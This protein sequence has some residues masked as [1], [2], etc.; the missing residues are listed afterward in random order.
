MSDEASS[1]PDRDNPF[2]TYGMVAGGVGVPLSMTG[3]GDLL[4]G[5]PELLALAAAIIL[6]GIGVMVAGARGGLGFSVAGLALAAVLVF[7]IGPAGSVWVL[8]V[9]LLAL[10][11]VLA[12]RSASASKGR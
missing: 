6:S 9:S 10:G 7:A 8:F 4:G 11:V 5:A 3:L 1:T 12:V 2:A